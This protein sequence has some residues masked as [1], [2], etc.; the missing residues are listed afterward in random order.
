MKQS[1]ECTKCTVSASNYLSHK[2]IQLINLLI[3]N[4]NPWAFQELSLKLFCTRRHLNSA[5]IQCKAKPHLPKT[6]TLEIISHFDVDMWFRYNEK[7]EIMEF[8][9]NGKN[10][11]MT[12]K[13]HHVAQGFSQLWRIDFEEI[14]FSVMGAIIFWFL[15]NVAVDKNRNASHWYC[16]S[17]FM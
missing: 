9:H 3:L 7:N 4:S 8:L 16:Y 17:I 13:Y 12:Y 6:K 5:V 11:V 14:N 2:Q 10:E 15:I 1:E